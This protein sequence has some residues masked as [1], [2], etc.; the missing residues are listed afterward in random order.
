MKKFWEVVTC[1]LRQT[2][3][4]QLMC[5]SSDLYVQLSEIPLLYHA[6]YDL[7]MKCFHVLWLR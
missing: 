7:M 6:G 3:T 5:Y 4:K 1:L 2:H